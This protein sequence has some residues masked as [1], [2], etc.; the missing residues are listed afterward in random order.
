MTH[1]V[2]VVYH[3]GYGHT[4]KQAEAVAEGAGSVE[5]VACQLIPVAD[6]EAG[7]APA[8]AAL[9]SCD[10]MI[11]GSP[12]YMGSAS[13]AFK[14]FMEATSGRWMEQRWAMKLAA[15]FTNSGS[16][17]GDKQNTLIQFATL[18]AQHGMLWVNLNQMPGNNSTAGSE[19]D[20]NRLG[21]SL[22]A[23]AQSAVDAGPDV[24]PT[25]ADL[26]TARA[27]GVHV[28][29]CAKRWNG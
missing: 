4:Q 18:A 8:W 14:A 28:A 21:A 19:D 22:G 29:A 26:E 2:C 6:L 9:D 13:A 11:F 16:Q 7:D 27:F 12:T 25:Q 1:T 20:L 3:S 24:G 17:N 23:M 15:G 10:A 5:G